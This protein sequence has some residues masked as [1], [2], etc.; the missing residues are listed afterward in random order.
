MGGRRGGVGGGERWGRG[1][2]G[3]GK[4]REGKRQDR[5]RIGENRGGGTK[6]GTHM[7]PAFVYLHFFFSDN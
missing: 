7:P 2:V 1:N 6:T 5:E 4:G 3:E